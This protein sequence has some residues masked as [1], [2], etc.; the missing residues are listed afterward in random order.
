MSEK[1]KLPR[2]QVWYQSFKNTFLF[3]WL[4]SFRSV[5]SKS[6]TFTRGMLWTLSATAIIILLPLAIEATIDGELKMMELSGPGSMNPDVQY[7]PY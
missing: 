7:R 2:Y 5:S 6:W 4:L 3:R 1:V